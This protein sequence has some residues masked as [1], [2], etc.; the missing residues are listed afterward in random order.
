MFPAEPSAPPA[1]TAPSRLA[2]EAF[3]LKRKRQHIERYEKSVEDSEIDE[4][5]HTKMVDVETEHRANPY[6]HS[7]GIGGGEADG[8][9]V[10]EGGQATVVCPI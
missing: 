3:A 5:Q 1:S 6:L 4:S 7:L 10:M 8:T 9:A 2:E